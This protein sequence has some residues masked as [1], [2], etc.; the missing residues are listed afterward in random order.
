MMLSQHA[1]IAKASATIVYWGAQEVTTGFTKWVKSLGYVLYRNEKQ[2]LQAGG[3]ILL[4]AFF[5]D[6]INH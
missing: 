2:Y 4:G 6:H 5:F 3:G 1:K